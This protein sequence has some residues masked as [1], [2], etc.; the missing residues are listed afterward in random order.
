MDRESHIL[1]EKYQSVNEANGIVP[2]NK[3]EVEK[4]NKL[5]KIEDKDDDYNTYS[6]SFSSDDTPENVPQDSS[7]K[8]TYSDPQPDTKPSEKFVGRGPG[9]APERKKLTF[10]Q[11]D[12]KSEKPFI[13]KK[14]EKPF[15]TKK[16][17]KPVTGGFKNFLKKGAGLGL[18]GAG[19]ALKY[20]LQAV[21]PFSKSGLL[22]RA[23]SGAKK[24]EN[25]ARTGSPDPYDAAS[26]YFAT[27][28]KL[29]LSDKK[30][31][32]EQQK[33]VQDFRQNYIYKRDGDVQLNNDVANLFGGKVRF[34]NIE[35]EIKGLE[36]RKQQKAAGITS[37]YILKRKAPIKSAAHL[38]NIIIDEVVDDF[39]KGVPLHMAYRNAYKGIPSHIFNFLMK[40]KLL[41]KV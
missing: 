11:S 23:A 6:R 18:K 26:K 35:K 32:V 17:E 25:W 37:N 15:I 9:D 12:Q 3:K 34:D 13:T 33:A 10:N 2:Y 1:F 14:S 30:S 27:G 19:K 36:N 5:Q 40:N 4:R 31:G 7:V 24:A 21:D 41:P 8:F 16:S 20:G 39:R 29:D 28:G 38:A 22:G